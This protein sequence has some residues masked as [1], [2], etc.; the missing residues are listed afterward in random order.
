MFHTIHGKSAVPPCVITN[1]LYSISKHRTTVLLCVKLLFL[2]Y[3]NLIDENQIS[4]NFMLK[5]LLFFFFL[6]VSD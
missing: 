4:F 5:L 6:F 2:S 3:V 1:R